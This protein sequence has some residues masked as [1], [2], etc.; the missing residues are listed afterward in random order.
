MVVF[1]DAGHVGRGRGLLGGCQCVE[2][3]EGGGGGGGRGGGGGGGG[4]SG[5]EKTIVGIAPDL[6]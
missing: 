1:E 3:G 2:M 4:G 5:A 6:V